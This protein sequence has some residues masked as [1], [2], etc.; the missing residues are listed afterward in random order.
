MIRLHAAVAATAFL[1]VS[2]TPALA[3]SQQ[4]TQIE[5][6]DADGRSFQAR[7]VQRTVQR[8]TIRHR[9]APYR[10]AGVAKAKQAIAAAHRLDQRR[11]TVIRALMRDNA[12][13]R[14]DLAPIPFI[15]LA[16]RMPL[17]KPAAA[18][19]DV[20]VATVLLGALPPEA[21][22]LPPEGP[23]QPVLAPMRVITPRGA[24]HAALLAKTAE[25]VQDCG[26]RVISAVR[27]RAVIAG[28]RGR[29]SK[30]RN[31]RARDLQ[32]PVACLYTHLANFG[33]GV[34]VDYR[35]V[36]HVHIDERGYSCRFF[37]YGH[38]PRGCHYSLPTET[39]FAKR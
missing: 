30:H 12:R 1:A 33:G 23:R 16:A 7:P 18:F 13:L 25:L 4:P 14:A 35:S 9:P 37:H 6:F 32:G 36:G 28:S 11:L 20:P 22:R 2:A 38:G 31:G 5:A 21:P 17:D 24:N 39:K 15:R 8:R 34:S 10:R 3:R 29:P 19:R 27:P 26:A